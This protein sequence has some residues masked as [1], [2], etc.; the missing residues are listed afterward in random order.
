MAL[1]SK[2]SNSTLND[3]AGLSDDAKRMYDILKR[4]ESQAPNDSDISN[5]DISDIEDELDSDDVP[6][7]G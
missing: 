4:M 7:E 6:E 1:Q 5:I 2:T 3:T